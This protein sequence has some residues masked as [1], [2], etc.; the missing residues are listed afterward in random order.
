MK[1]FSSKTDF[2]TTKPKALKWV[3]N[4]GLKLTNQQMAKFPE[5]FVRLCTLLGIQFC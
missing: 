4:L 2:A 5:K 3:Q 1:E